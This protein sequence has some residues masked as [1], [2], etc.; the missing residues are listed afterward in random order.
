MSGRILKFPSISPLSALYYVK[1][2]KKVLE[3]G[4]EY[5]KT[6]HE[7]LGRI[8]SELYILTECHA[9]TSIPRAGGDVSDKK[10]DEFTK[11][12]N[13]LKKFEL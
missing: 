10:A 2:M 6:E 9:C 1:V 13:V 3:K 11:K 5:V 8:L 7:R 12:Q 4:V